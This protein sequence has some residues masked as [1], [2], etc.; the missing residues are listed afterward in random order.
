MVTAL[1]AFFDD[2]TLP[3]DELDAA[4]DGGSIA[5]L[6]NPIS[7]TTSRGGIKP[8]HARTTSPPTHPTSSG[9][10]SEQ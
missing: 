3:S 9:L 1:L 2:E 5:S 10:S 4:I 6:L 8:S 7:P